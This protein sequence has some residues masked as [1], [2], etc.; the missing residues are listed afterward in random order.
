MPEIYETVG[1]VR[2]RDHGTS[3]KAAAKVKRV[4]LRELALRFARDAGPGGF[5]DGELKSAYPE[6]PESSV[7]KRRTELAAENWLLDTG[8]TRT[9]E[10][11]Q[12]EKVWI[13]RDFQRGIA[14]PLLEPEPKPSKAKRIAEL[15][16]AIE[17]HVSM[18][19]DALPYVEEGAED[20]CYSPEGQK[21][22]AAL[23]RRMKKLVNT[24]ERTTK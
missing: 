5:T 21:R 16:A 10:H 22:I 13:L 2:N 4:T 9:N 15:E 23:A 12:E 1:M 17:L 18:I 3:V 19:A 7:R 14:P 20:D 24:H 8:R 6:A 11:G